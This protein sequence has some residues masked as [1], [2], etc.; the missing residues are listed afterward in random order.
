MHPLHQ[1]LVDAAGGSFPPVDGVVEVHA[2]LRTGHHCVFEFTGHSFVLTDRPSDDVMERG[3]HGFG[4]TS[5]PDLLRWLVADNGWIGNHD[6][7]LVALGTGGGTLPQRHD[8][9]DHPRVRRSRRHRHDVRVHGDETGF[10][11]IGR[12]LVDRVELAVELFDG[13]AAASGHGRALISHGRALVEPDTL[14]WAQVAPGNAASLRAFLA[15][16]FRPIGAE[17]LLIP[18]ER[19]SDTDAS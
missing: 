14:L 2:P 19:G 17:T 6:A 16:G 11:T 5:H 1:A 15:S 9:D 8:L 4:A 13:T 7:V 12:G 10:V 3:A 18:E